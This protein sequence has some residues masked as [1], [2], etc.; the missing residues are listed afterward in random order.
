MGC[1]R[2]V[3]TGTDNIV[4]QLLALPLGPGISSLIDWDDE[5]RGFLESP[6]I[7]LLGRP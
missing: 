4:P 5:S 1:D 3:F 6:E 2:I 7:W